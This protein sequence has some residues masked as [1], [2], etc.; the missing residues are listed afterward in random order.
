[1]I[2]TKRSKNTEPRRLRDTARPDAH[3]VP[4]TGADLDPAFVNI[5]QDKLSRGSVHHADMTRVEL[6]HRYDVILVCLVRS[7]SR[8]RENVRRTF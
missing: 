6:L 3:E 7:A 8:T 1:M 5:A 2:P 4:A